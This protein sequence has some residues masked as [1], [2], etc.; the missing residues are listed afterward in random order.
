MQPPSLLGTNVAMDGVVIDAIV[1]RQ[2]ITASCEVT[3]C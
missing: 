3:R 1:D 2:P